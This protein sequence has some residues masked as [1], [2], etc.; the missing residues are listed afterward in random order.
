MKIFEWAKLAIKGLPN[1]DAIVRGVVNDVKFQH[2]SLPE[3]DQ[4]EIARR[5]LICHTCPLNSFNARLSKEYLDLYGEHYK[6][7][8]TD[9]HCSI[10]SCNVNLKTAALDQDCGLT[11]FNKNN[12]DK[13][14]VLKWKKY[15]K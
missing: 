5:R 10:C 15:E 6:T 8:R 11:E 9:L 7:E 12:P 4:E 2:K 3:D 1:L 13:V 14:Q